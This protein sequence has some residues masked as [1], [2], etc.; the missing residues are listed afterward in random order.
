[1]EALIFCGLQGAG[2]T[3]FYQER[4]FNTHLRS[5][6]DLLKTRA[7][8]ALFL[9]TCLESG[10][11]FVVDNTN[12]TRINRSVYLKAAK[13]KNFTVAGYYFSS[14]LQDALARN[15][16]RPGKARVPEQAVKATLAKLERPTLAEGFDQLYYV[17][18]VGGIFTVSEW[19]DEI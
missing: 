17:S 16:A 12:P 15:M 3:S 14:K 18:L 6:L 4:F 1:M 11:R 8:E 7:R 5:S 19:R 10:Q 9:K 13:R 2:K